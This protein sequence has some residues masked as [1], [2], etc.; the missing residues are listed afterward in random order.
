MLFEKIGCDSIVYLCLNELV[1]KCVFNL[2]SVF[3]LPTIIQN[4]AVLI[5]TIL[6][7]YALN[8]LIMRSKIRLLFGK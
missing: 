7:L 8:E 3:S 5:F 1:I 6:I 2:V 4:S